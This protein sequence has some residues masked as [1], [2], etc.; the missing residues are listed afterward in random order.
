LYLTANLQIIYIDTISLILIIN[1][2]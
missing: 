2:S 1:G